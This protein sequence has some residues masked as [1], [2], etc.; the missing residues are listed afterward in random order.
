[1]SGGLLQNCLNCVFHFFKK[2]V[3]QF[4]SALGFI[5]GEGAA[6]IPADH[7]M[8]NDLHRLPSEFGFD[9]V[10]GSRDGRIALHFLDPPPC[11]DGAVVRIG[12][13]G[14]EGTKQLGREKRPLILRKAQGFFPNFRNAHVPSV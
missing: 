11:F 7:P 10:P 12:E 4:G 13:D 2:P 9:L 6:E 5:I 8:V 3:S 14:R 1:M